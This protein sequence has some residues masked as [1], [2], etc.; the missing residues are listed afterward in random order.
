MA[1]A[2]AKMMMAV[3]ATAHLPYKIV[4]AEEDQRPARDP[5]KDIAGPFARLDSE[6][7]DEGAD[8]RGEENVAGA[9]EGHGRE[10]L[11]PPPALPATGQHERQPVGRNGGMGEGDDEPGHYDGK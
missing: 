10:R 1:V 4:K 9:A 11:D 8:N 3:S 2:R 5:G 7:D 6:P